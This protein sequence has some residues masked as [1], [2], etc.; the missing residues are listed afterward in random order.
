MARQRQGEPVASPLGSRDP[1]CAA[2]Q[3]QRLAYTFGSEM[4]IAGVEACLLA[5][6]HLQRCR[7]GGLGFARVEVK[8]TYTIP[9][10]LEVAG[11]G[12]E[13]GWSTPAQPHQAAVFA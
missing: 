5:L 12:G 13:V 3:P 4:T 10:R 1:H 9:T 8:G 6:F 7:A 2:K 11:D